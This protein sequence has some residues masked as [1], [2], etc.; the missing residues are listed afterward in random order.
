MQECDQ[1]QAKWDNVHQ[2][3][4]TEHQ[5]CLDAH[6][7]EQ[8]NPNSG[9][10]PNSIC[11]H[12]ECQDLHDAIFNVVEPESQSDVQQCR[13][14]VNQYLAAVQ[15]SQQGLQQLVQGFRDQAQHLLALGCTPGGQGDATAGGDASSNCTSGDSSATNQTPLSASEVKAK[16]ADFARSAEQYVKD[17]ADAWKSVRKSPDLSGSLGLALDALKMANTAAGGEV[18]TTI[19]PLEKLSNYVDNEQTILSALA[20]RSSDDWVVQSG[21]NSQDPRTKA[22]AQAYLDSWSQRIGNIQQLIQGFVPAAQA[23]QTVL[24][25]PDV[26]AVRMAMAQ[27]TLPGLDSIALGDIISHLNNCS[28]QIATIQSQ[29]QSARSVVY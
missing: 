23:I 16:A 10:G 25:D 13:W 28:V 1:L 12:S 4:E 17:A 19:G 29:L 9:S 20:Q 26:N 24:A 5:N 14:D 21:I 15:Q 22:S 2:Q 3:M 8:P 7:R 27:S 6:S 11:T 18:P